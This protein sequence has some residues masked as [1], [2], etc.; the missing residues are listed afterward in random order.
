MWGGGGVGGGLQLTSMVW[1]GEGGGEVRILSEGGEGGEGSRMCLTLSC[2]CR[3][4]R[5]G[6]LVYFELN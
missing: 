2:G 1:V 4:G 5:A 6:G 3:C